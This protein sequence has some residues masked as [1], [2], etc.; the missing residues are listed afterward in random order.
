YFSL[1]AAR[2]SERLGGPPVVVDWLEV[3]S[4][5]FWRESL[6][7]V[8]GAL[9]ERLQR[10]CLRATGPAFTFAELTA[11]RMRE[12]GHRGDVRLLRGLY[13]GTLDPAPADAEREPLVVYLGRHVPEKRVAAIPPAIALARRE[14][15][16]L[17]ATLFGDG[18]ERVRVVAEIERL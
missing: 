14:I 16:D 8:A 12:L 10:L 17:C 11:R 6:G 2:L 4:P 9:G 3:W 13:G 15:P 7:G 1:L 5:E 18:P